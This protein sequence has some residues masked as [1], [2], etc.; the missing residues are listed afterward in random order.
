MQS[1]GGRP[2]SRTDWLQV[3]LSTLVVSA[4]VVG[5]GLACA[6]Q[7]LGTM[8]TQALAGHEVSRCVVVVVVVY[9]ILVVLVVSVGGVCVWVWVWECMWVWVSA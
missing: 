4:A 7:P 1:L 9:G 2:S 3:V 8:W 5:S 6:P